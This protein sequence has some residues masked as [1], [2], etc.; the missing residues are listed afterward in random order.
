VTAALCGAFLLSGAAALLFEALWFR[1]AGLALGSSVWASSAVLAAFMAGLALGNAAAARWGGLVRRPLRAYA[2]LEAGVALVGLGLVLGMPGVAE[3]LAPRLAGLRGVP[4]LLNGV[5]GLVSFAL[6]LLPATAMGASLPLLAR[7]L[8]RSDPRFG[9]ALGRLYGWNTLGG[10]AGAVAGEA[11]LVPALGLVGTAVVAAS[12]DLAAAAV[13]MAL[14]RRAAPLTAPPSASGRP[15]RRPRAARLLAAALAAGGVLLGLEVVWLRFLQLFV[16]GT[17]LAFALMLATILAGIGGGGLAVGAWIRRDPGAARFLPTLALLGG[18]ATIAAYAAF[19]PVHVP[20][21]LAGAEAGRT[22][23]LSLRL[24]LPTSF[25]SGVLFTLL[26]A[27]LREEVA[28]D[29]AAAGWLTLANT[30]GAALGAPLA[31]LAL[32][33][34]LGVEGSLFVLALAYAPVAWAAR[35][36]EGGPRTAALAAALALALAAAFFPFGLMRGRFVRAVVDALGADGSRLVAV[37]EGQT[38]TALLLQRSWG[39]RPLYQKLVTNA[40]SMTSSTFYG[41]RY[42]KLFAHWALAVR[43]EARRALLISYGLGNTGEALVL[44]PGLERVDVVDT[45][46]T[47]LGLGPLVARDGAKDPLADPRV[48]VHVEDGRFHLLAGTALYDVVT[49]E[50][51]PPR[52]AGVVNLYTLEYFRLVRKRL[53]RGGVATHWL[54]VNQLSVADARAIVRAFCAAFED[55]SL[56]SGAGYDWM[57]AGTNGALEAPSE[58]AF[59]R[60][61]REEGRG[62]GLRELGVEAPEQLGAL[63]VADGPALAAW[64]GEEEPLVDDRPGRLRHGAPPPRDLAAFRAFQDARACAERF[65]SSAF[66]ARLWPEGLR[67]R[68]PSWF[69][70]R[71]VFDRDFDEAGRPGALADLWA[72]LEGSSLRTLP[73]LQLDSEPRISAIA[74]EGWARGD[75]HPA[76]AFHLGAA[77]LA[78]RDYVEAA[79]FFGEAGSDANPFHPSS[80]LR[81]LALGLDGRVADALALVESASPAGL[82]PHAVPWRAWLLGKLRDAARQTAATRGGP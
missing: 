2:L 82:P 63:F 40:Y 48:R 44:A 60:P 67:S 56:W 53:A 47:I 79:R 24:M 14:D 55:C 38:E 18:V 49:A 46:R 66:V 13:A 64:A 36:R 31:G 72:V 3:G 73:L 39:G 69:A 7:A 78:E 42:M 10:V 68:T 26:G 54:P 19:D 52:G 75:R 16:F 80:L 34:A 12:L 29:A 28:G 27:A 58:E 41:R 57:L 51:P 50:P 76:L 70:W 5:R 8:T 22:S 71:G 81:A 65:G 20:V 4:A 21:V 33:P 1:L 59:S 9:V 11:V 45:S 17:Q 25:L 74:R 32:L 30:V 61:W 77:A 62:R 37:R 23:W 43:P 6:M 35:P 15:G